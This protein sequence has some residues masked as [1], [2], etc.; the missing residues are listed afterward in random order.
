MFRTEFLFDIN[1]D[2]NLYNRS[3]M[4]SL[5][6][7]IKRLEEQILGKLRGAAHIDRIINQ[8]IDRDTIVDQL[9]N[10]ATEYKNFIESPEQNYA[11]F[12]ELKTKHRDLLNK[13]VDD[14]DTDENS[15]A[16]LVLAYEDD[17]TKYMEDLKIMA[18]K[19]ELVLK[20]ENWPD[21]R[22]AMGKLEK[23]QAINKEQHVQS[24][25]LDKKT[26]DLIQIYNE[27]L[28]SFKNNMVLWNQRI[29]AYENEDKKL[30]DE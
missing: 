24:V 2:T 16:E 18:Q 21:L 22:G 19:S 15:K 26:E 6:W 27:I 13:L 8:S 20:E 1:D 3:K 10:V 11:R 28:L 14:N 5:E 7:R 9:N 23:L 29:E 25:S 17:L 30:D 12:V 4:N